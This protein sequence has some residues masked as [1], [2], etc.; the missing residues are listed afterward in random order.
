MTKTD[1]EEVF[2]FHFRPA[3]RFWHW[4]WK[5]VTSAGRDAGKFSLVF[6]TKEYKCIHSGKDEEFQSMLPSLKDHQAS[7]C[8]HILKTSSSCYVTHC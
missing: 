5:K 8:L 2:I 4:K 7:G 6:K 3:R 1:D